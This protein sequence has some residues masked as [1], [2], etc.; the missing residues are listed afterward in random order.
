MPQTR[1]QTLSGLQGLAA[2]VGL[3]LPLSDAGPGPA[4]YAALLQSREI[5]GAAV[6]TRYQ[7]PADSGLAT[8]TL[9]EVYRPWGKTAALRR[10]AAIKKLREHMDVTTDRRTG[11]VQLTVTTP[12]AVL[13]AGVVQ[14]LLDLLNEFNLQTRQSTAAS[15]RRFTE[16]RFKQAGEDLHHAEDELAAFLKRNR[17]Y[18]SSPDLTFEQER[19]ARAVT[20]CQTLFTSLAQAYEQARIEEVRDTPVI[21]IVEHPFVPVRPD[22]R[23]LLLKAF[24]ALVGGL[25]VGMVIALVRDLRNRAKQ[26]PAGEL[27]EF[28]ALT[29]E[30]VQDLAHPIKSIRRWSQSTGSRALP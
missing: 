27:A 16:E 8:A 5:L 24:G 28:V 25:L 2:Q 3:S 13:S 19:L 26:G 14:R 4:F 11:V 12:S 17:D 29:G 7:F 22:P 15:E 10:E 20:M 9:V 30:M 18:R 1:R 21:T 23:Q 6:D